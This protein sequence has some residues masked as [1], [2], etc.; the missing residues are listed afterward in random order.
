M[1]RKNNLYI[2]I[3]LYI[4]WIIIS[5]NLSPA[6]LFLGL[7]ISLSVNF[8]ISYSSFTK[9]IA[10]KFIKNFFL[11]LYYGMVIAFQVFVASYKVAS[12]VLNP[13]HDFKPGIIKTSVDVGEK[14]QIMKLTILANIITLTPGTV[15]VSANINNNQ[16]YIHWIHM[17]GGT[18]EELKDKMVTDFDKIVRRIFS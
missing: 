15:V 2:I 7:L 6:S 16:L 14:N 1:K 13:Y 8:V 4:V 10:E 18:E 5:S 11:F 17:E 12:F 3:L 9:K